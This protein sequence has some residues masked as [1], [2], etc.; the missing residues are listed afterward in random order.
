MILLQ[1]ME[2]YMNTPYV[3][4][5]KSLLEANY[6]TMC[7]CLAVDKLFYAT[8]PN[9]EDITFKTL[10]ECGANFE[11][12][13]S[14]EQSKLL[15]MG[16]KSENIICSLPIKTIEDLK[17]MYTNGCRYFVYDCI[18][19]LEHLENHCPE[20]KK[21]LRISL[22]D[23]F[24][25]E[26]G[27][28]M[29]F[30][31]IIA[32]LN[33]GFV[34]DGYTFYAFCETEEMRK[35]VFEKTFERL[36]FFLSFHNNKKTLINIGGNFKNP[37]LDENEFF[38]YVNQLIGDIKKKYNNVIFYAEPGRAIVQDAFDIV[39]T[40]LIK[41]EDRV[42]ID[43][44]SQIIKMPPLDIAPFSDEIKTSENEQIYFHEYLC[45][46]NLLFSKNINFSINEGMQLILKGCGAYSFCFANRFHSTDKPCII[47]GE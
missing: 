36:L 28:G 11:I 32:L 20:A 46:N 23:I 3:I 2:N 19:E 13:S 41:K 40:V 21:I 45:S 6:H 22:N 44:H 38:V 35:N 14:K 33:K 24:Y 17:I 4:F 7:N 31:D 8:K 37:K 15:A 18:Q 25:D 9:I 27:Y 26:I 10:A 12:V 34:P 5:H 42:Y 16:V 43:A 1:K 30:D 29:D 47:E 39:T